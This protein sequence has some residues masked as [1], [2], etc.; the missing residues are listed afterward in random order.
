MEPDSKGSKA[1]DD[2]RRFQAESADSRTVDALQAKLFAKALVDL[3]LT[4]YSALVS[5]RG[6]RP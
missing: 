5:D 6:H 4:Q 3:G 1:V 2:R